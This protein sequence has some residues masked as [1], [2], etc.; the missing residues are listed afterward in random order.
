MAALTPPANPPHTYDV[1]VVGSGG[2]GLLAACAAADTGARVAVVERTELL[3]GTTA[4]SGG[5]LWIPNHPHLASLGI[6]DT[7]EEALCYLRRISLGSTGPAVLESFVDNGPRLVSYLE[8]D[9]GIPLFAVE[10]PDYHPDF[11]G[12]KDGRSLEPLPLNAA[13]LGDVLTS[14]RTSLRPPT[15][16]AEGRV[17]LPAEVIDQRRR[18]HV[19]TQGT[20]LVAGLVLAGRRRG[21]DFFTSCR[22]QELITTDGRV[23]GVMV[24]AADGTTVFHAHRAVILASGGF[25]WNAQMRADFLPAVPAAPVSPPGNEGDGLRLALEL[26]ARHRGMAEAWWTAAARVPGEE[27]DGRP[28]T[29]NLVRELACPG[30]ILVNA[31]GERFVDEAS[32]YNDLGK[33]FFR[34]DQQS[35]TFPNAKAWLVVDAEFRQTYSIAGRDPDADAPEWFLSETEIGALG[36]LA[37]ISPKTLT[38]TVSE[39]NTYA[40]HGE[41]PHFE[42]G[43]NRHD[44]YNGDRGHKPNPCLRPLSTPPYYAVPIIL[45][46][47]GTKGGVV[48]DES[49][50]PLRPDGTPIPGLF[51]CGNVAAS[52][53]GP[54][55]AGSGASLGPALTAAMVAGQ[56]AA[57]PSTTAH[58]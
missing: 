37:G 38:E 46:I 53:M 36:T 1:V 45:G 32:S 35:H 44:Q 58:H 19:L 52:L 30:S 55:Y 34:F 10:R 3:G 47:N 54:G 25:E 51:A 4:I 7:R 29:R 50:R 41:D 31:A 48:T 39:F 23:S 8:R 5:Q 42:R 13:A 22:M 17:G 57:T 20:A 56:Q 43:D 14:V 49:G 16:S 33:A 26:G 15:T 18:D 40:R 27:R 12:A 21:V 9:L 11:P 2:A 6:K 24:S 28:L